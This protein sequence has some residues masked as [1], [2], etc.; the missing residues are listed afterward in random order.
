TPNY[1]SA[2][3]QARGR[4]T[5]EPTRIF[6]QTGRLWDPDELLEAF[7]PGAASSCGQVHLT[8]TSADE[9]TLPDD[10]LKDIREGGVGEKKD[11]SRSAMCQ[12]VISQVKRRYWSVEA[13]IELLEKYPNG[14]AAKYKKRLRRET[15]R[16]YGKATGGTSHG[17]GVASAANAA[18][19]SGSPA[20]T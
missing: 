11:K 13:I 3:K 4:I 12:S 1:P 19:P 2:A 6:E 10:L 17:G 18:A 15:E 9:A 5:V 7:Q 20:P 8:G 16:S 14:I